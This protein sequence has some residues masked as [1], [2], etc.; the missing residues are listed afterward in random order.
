L[1]NELGALKTYATQ[2]T[3]QVYAV[4]VASEALYRQELTGDQ[5][6][7]IMNQVKPILPGVKLG[8]A[9]SWN[10]WNDGSG[11]AIAKVAD[12]ILSN[13]FAY[14]QGTAVASAP[15]TFFDD[16]GQALEHIQGVR[17]NSDFEFWV[18]ET[19]WPGDGGTNYGAALAGTSNA[20]EY[21]KNGICGMRTWGVNVFAFEAF[22]EPW[23]PDSIGDSGQPQDEKH[24]GA[25]DQNRVAKYTLTC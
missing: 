8:T 19:G 13:A 23:K 11:D 15:T 7:S 25:Y 4:T 22:D 24:W 18:G 9:D 17:G 20:A 3:D 2:Y 12:I 10:K 16:V 5:I 1:N 21:W 14:W 6:V